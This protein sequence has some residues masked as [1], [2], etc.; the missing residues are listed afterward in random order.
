LNLGD[1]EGWYRAHVE[2]GTLPADNLT[3]PPA[4]RRDERGVLLELAPRESAVDF[5][6]RR[7]RGDETP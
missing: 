7:N 3:R 2:F 6:A 4:A 5:F 1:L